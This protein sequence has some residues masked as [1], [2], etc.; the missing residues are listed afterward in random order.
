MFKVSK[1][2]SL[3]SGS[4]VMV[5]V[6]ERDFIS[7]TILWN[8]NH[9]F[10]VEETTLIP[11]ASSPH[12][13]TQITTH[14]WQNVSTS[15]LSHME[16]M[17]TSLSSTWI[18]IVKKVEQL[19][20]TLSLGMGIPRT[21]H[22]W[23]DSVEMAVMFQIT[24]RLPKTICL[25]GKRVH[26]NQRKPR[27]VML[28]VQRFISNYERYYIGHGFQLQY[29]STDES[30]WTHRTGECGGDFTTPHGVLTSPSYPDAYPD[31]SDC[32]YNISQPN[33]TV[34]MLTFHSLHI[35]EASN[36]QYDYLE[37]TYETSGALSDKH[38]G[39]HSSASF[40]QTLQTTSNHVWMR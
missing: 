1:H 9:S 5:L 31:N 17:S 34:I 20:I 2:H 10:P 28:S 21:L 7:S 38:C 11:V 22:S 24:F 6:M 29:E 25:S 32:I 8:W 16:N 37:I 36:C 12:P 39:Y 18:L 3:I 35:E 33:D 15:F 40:P 23:E 30:T 4:T 26:R 14:T 19:L 13:Y 27:Y